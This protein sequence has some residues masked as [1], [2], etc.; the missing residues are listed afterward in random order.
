[1]RLFYLTLAMA[2]FP[3][4]CSAGGTVEFEHIDRL[5]QQKPQVRAFLLESLAM[6]GSA[7]AE[8]RLG[9]HF[10]QLSAYRLG[11]YT[12]Q[13]QRKGGSAH[14]AVLVS[15]CT[16]Y[17]FLD[18]SGKVISAGTDQELN[19]AQVQEELTAVVLREIGESNTAPD[20]P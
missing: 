9:P 3:L 2:L 15:L 19:A 6:P 10:K 12:L 5:L 11:P 4:T 7:Y 13:A 14:G 17:Q 20:C 8:V 16:K 18:D 1:M